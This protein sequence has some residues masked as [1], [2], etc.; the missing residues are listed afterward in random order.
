MNNIGMYGGSFDPLHNGHIKCINKALEGCK[1]L[2]VVLSYSK[3]RDRI[4]YKIRASWLKQTLRG[5][6]ESGR[7]DLILVE[8]TYDTK[9]SYNWNTGKSD[10]LKACGVEKFDVVFCGD[11]YRLAGTF[12]KLYPESKICYFERDDISSSNIWSNPLR[13]WDDMPYFVQR[14]FVKKI[15]IIGSEST[16]KSTLAENLAKYYNTVFVREIGRDISDRATSEFTMPDMDFGEILI[17]H[18]DEEYNQLEKANKLLFL[19]TDALT[20]MF[21]SYELISDKT[22]RD[23][24]VQLGNALALYSHYD[25]I[26]FLEPSVPFVQDGTRNE[27]IAENREYY[28]DKLKSY[29][30]K[31]GYIYHN[32]SSKSYAER[33]KEAIEIINKSFFNLE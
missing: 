14:N 19:D 1:K 31:F 24:T 12:S 7:V 27:S 23:K 6:I 26:L 20:T 28:S 18:K 22:T 2:F 9:Q 13:Y 17:R 10:I 5:Y 4:D 8:D 33:T 15:L 11:E 16:G 21:Y 3:V 30:D 32:I 29:Y 25:L